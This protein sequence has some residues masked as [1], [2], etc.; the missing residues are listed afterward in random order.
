MPNHIKYYYYSQYFIYAY[1][2]VIHNL[3]AF[4]FVYSKYQF[5]QAPRK[6]DITIEFQF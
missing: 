4:N 6:N 1:G 2:Y 5:P 3:L